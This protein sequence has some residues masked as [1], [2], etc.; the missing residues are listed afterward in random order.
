MGMEEARPE[1]KSYICTHVFERSRPVLYVTRP[2]G[3]W[4]LLCG[5][6]HPNSASAYR[7]AGINHVLAHD[8]SVREVLDLNV[9]EEAERTVVGG[10]WVRRIFQG[11]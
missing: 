5:D 1:Q 2:E 3:D 9:D 6:E 10:P 8:P 11:G 4:C 7:V